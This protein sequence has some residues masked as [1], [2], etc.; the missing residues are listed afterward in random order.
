MTPLLNTPQWIVVLLVPLNNGKTDKLPVDYRTGSVGVDAHNRNYHTDY[1]TARTLAEKWGPQFTVGF[2]LTENDPF[3]C[4]DIDNALQP[5]N[6][7]SPL[8]Q[9][10]CAAL[11]NTVIEVSQ[12][13]RGLHVW[14]QGIVPRHSMKRVDL[15]IEFY[16]EKRFIAIGHSQVGD[17]SQPCPTVR[18]FVEHYFPP[19]ERVAAVGDG[20]APE[21]RGPEDDDELIRRALQSKS[22]RSAFGG[23]ASFADLWEC[24]AT[25]LGRAYPPDTSSSEPFDRSSADA[26]LAQHLAFWTGRDGERIDRLMRQSGLK[27]EKYDR[28]DYL[29]RT[30]ENACSMQREVLQ[31]KPAQPSGLPALPGSPEILGTNEVS[32]ETPHALEPAPA[33]APGMTPITGSTF[34]SPA[35]QVTLFAGCVYVVDQHK[36]LVPGG[37][38]VNPER[39]RAIFGGYTF[40]MDTR[41]ERTTRNAWEAFTESQVLKAPRADGTCFRPDLA[42]GVMVVDAGRT[43]V[44]TYWPVNAPRKKGDVTWFLDHVRKLFPDQR[45]YCI[46]IYYMAACVQH[47]GVKFQWA[48]LIQGVEGNGKTLLSRCVAEAIGRRYVHWPKASKIAKQFNG[49][50]RGKT[51]F[52]V[53]DIHTSEN[54]DVIEELK[55]MITGG[56][57]LEIES[58]GVDQVS[59]EICGNF[60]FNTNHKN[61]LRK[62]RNDRRFAV[63]YCAQQTV[64]DL[65]RDGMAGDY[66]SRMYRRLK[67]EGGYAEVAEFLWTLKIPD[68]FNPAT[69]CQRAPVTSSTDEAIAQSLGRVEQEILEAVSQELPGFAGGWI[70]SIQ[71]DKLIEK[72]GRGGSVPPNR[73][74]DM[75]R[76]LGYDW[77][78]ALPNG[79]VHNIIAPDSGKPRLYI[80]AGHPA[81]SLTQPAEIARAYTSAQGVK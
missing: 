6:T 80:K 15:A 2:V 37:H 51:F 62:T 40:A 18:A 30:I 69:G 48:P 60:I 59:D 1:T 49:W 70:S 27:R 32:D 3:F 63:L 78:P 4:L 13:G 74:R 54:V 79:R 65:V 71:V 67:Q 44:N 11:P 35:E 28:D 33:G 7:W 8:S 58:K 5:D 36:A 57:G 72:M 77:H 17:M 73:R 29:P 24:N 47:Q 61:G 81:L 52:A 22:A 39:F 68:E 26:A 42:Y 56:D 23:G 64:D 75:L 34:L 10:L 53:E 20:P 45:D 46:V 76:A 66:M 12:S 38:L 25:V 31:D 55:P 21:W 41:N 9:S 14:G 16:T 50:M 19:R 43:R